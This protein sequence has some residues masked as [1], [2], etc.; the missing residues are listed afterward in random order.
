V[1]PGPVAR[2]ACN[3]FVRITDQPDPFYNDSRGIFCLARKSTPFER[4]DVV[5]C[6]ITVIGVFVGAR[7]HMID[8]FD[9]LHERMILV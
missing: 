1:L 9:A 8:G 4:G 3:R 7:E 2:V 6:H 5:A